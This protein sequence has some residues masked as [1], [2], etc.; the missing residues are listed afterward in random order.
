MSHMS[1]SSKR[2]KSRLDMAA[3][4]LPHRNDRC[5]PTTE[6]SRGNIGEEERNVIDWTRW[7]GR[8]RMTSTRR[9]RAP[10]GVANRCVNI[11]MACKRRRS[12]ISSSRL[13]PVVTNY[14]AYCARRVKRATFWKGRWAMAKA[15]RR[16]RATRFHFRLFPMRALSD[17][18][19]RRRP[20]GRR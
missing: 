20:M 10:V 3:A 11:S 12:S 9:H 1:S 17:N 7:L 4:L 19:C 2:R 8:R 16:Q 14:A 13:F 5:C 15:R 6:A 18:A